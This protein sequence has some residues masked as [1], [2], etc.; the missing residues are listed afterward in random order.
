MYGRGN[1]QRVVTSTEHGYD[2]ITFYFK[3]LNE[4][5]EFAAIL[6][7]RFKDIGFEHM[8]LQRENFAHLPGDPDHF[9]TDGLANDYWPGAFRHFHIIYPNKPTEKDWEYL[10]KNANI[11]KLGLNFK[12]DLPNRYV[13]E[14]G[15]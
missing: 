10:R 12:K 11:R 6:Y 5:N 1:N 13:Q 4:T 8:H 14:K 15:K 3:G 9:H 7:N 2:F